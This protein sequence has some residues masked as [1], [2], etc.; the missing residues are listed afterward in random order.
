MADPPPLLGQ[1]ISHYRI[2][3]KLGGGGGGVVYKA[4]DTRL[5]RFVALKFLSDNLARDHQAL[6]RFKREAKAASALNHPNICTIYDIGEESG[7]AFIAM[8]FLDGET[9]RHRIAGK[10]IETETLL[11]LAVEIADGLDAAHTRGIVH[12][13]IKP[14]NIFVTER[15]HAKILDFG[16]AKVSA[17]L[18]MA[19]ADSEIMTG[20]DSTDLTSA[21]TMMGTVSYMSPEQVQAKELDA[22]TDLFSFGVVLYEMATGVLP[23]RG[24]SSGTTFSAILER[25]PVS[26]VRLNPDVPAELEWVINRALE[27]DRELRYQSAKEMRAELLRVRRDSISRLTP[28]KSVSSELL[29]NGT[30]SSASAATGIQRAVSES[31]TATRKKRVGFALAGMIVIAIVVAAAFGLYQFLRRPSHVPFRNM[32]MASVTSSGDTWAAAMSPEAKYVAMLRRD[33]D[34]R[35]SLWMRHLPTNSNNQIVQPGD[36]AIQDVTFAPDGNYVYFRSLKPGSGASDLFRVPVL[37]GVPALVIHDIDSPPS[38]LPSGRFCFTRVNGPESKAILSANEDGSDEK[39]VFSAN[40]TDY[41]DPGWSPD[42]RYIMVAEARSGGGKDMALIDVSAGRASH[43]FT[44]PTREFSPVSFT[45]MPDGTGMI[46]Q[47]HNEN[48]GKNQLGYVTYP[49]PE[50]HQITNDLSSYGPVSLSADGKTIGTVLSSSESS[51]EVFPASG[52]LLDD[53]A[54]SSLGRAYWFDWISD[55]Q[56]VLTTEDF[57]SIQVLSLDS[58]IRTTVFSSG[59]LQIYDLDMCGPKA[60]VFTGVPLADPHSSHIYALDLAGGTPRQV[61]T[62]KDQYVHCTPDGKWM[63]YR[64]SEDKGIHRIPAQGGQSEVLVGGEKHPGFLFSLSSDGKEL[65]VIVRGRKEDTPKFDF[66]SLET[67]QITRELAAPSDNVRA[68]ISPDRH[69]VAFKRKERGVENIW[70]QPTAGGAALPLTD[71]HLLRST[72]QYLRAFVWSP[73]G[74]RFGITRSSAKGDAV[75]LRDNGK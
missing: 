23:F 39:A 30:Y 18:K 60:V 50:F 48:T 38:F 49:V 52:R 35:D 15:G 74:K 17:S 13:D 28:A 33:S 19:A 3:E 70:L 75:I 14:A 42:G 67:G 40:T 61:T 8:E 68:T 72:S 24:E 25:A 51:L 44:L 46:V 59:E 58:G 71:F 43:F 37:G 22:R 66:I 32:T 62:G 4:Q 2:V 21:G 1:I 53:S 56:I 65:I 20:S 55:Q 45:W 12:R 69:N 47:Y 5:D 57:T 73:D 54:G 34:G 31:V 7:K 11:D 64:S 26:P 36:G 63:I 10:P 9:L 29:P 16:L 27:K 6:E 41:S